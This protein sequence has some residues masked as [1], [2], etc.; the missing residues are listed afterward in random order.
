MYQL[1]ESF[2]NTGG[3]AVH[4]RGDHRLNRS[5]ASCDERVTAETFPAALTKS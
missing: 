2:E 1:I 5:A 3:G 4:P